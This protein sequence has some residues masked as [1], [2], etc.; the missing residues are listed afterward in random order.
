MFDTRFPMEVRVRAEFFTTGCSGGKIA[1][2]RADSYS[3]PRGYNHELIVNV[4]AAGPEKG[5]KISIGS[6]DRER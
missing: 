1:D 3:T 6:F 5:Y 2:K 4:T